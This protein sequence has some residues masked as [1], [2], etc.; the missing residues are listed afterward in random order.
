MPEK[1]KEFTNIQN[2]FIKQIKLWKK[3][4]TASIKVMIVSLTGIDLENLKATIKNLKKKIQ[5]LKQVNF[6]FHEI[7]KILEKDNM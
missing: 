5:S 2:M 7:K 4:C 3:Q 6:D 1:E